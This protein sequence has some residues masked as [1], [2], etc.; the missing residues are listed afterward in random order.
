MMDAPESSSFILYSGAPFN[1][2]EAVEEGEG[3]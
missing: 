3:L 2:S 1:N